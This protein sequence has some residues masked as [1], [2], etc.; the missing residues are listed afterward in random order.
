MFRLNENRSYTFMLIPERTR[1]VSSVQIPAW[2]LKSALFFG[3]VIAGLIVLAVFNYSFILNQLSDNYSLRAENRRLKGQLQVF[4]VKL[5]TLET[6]VERIQNFRDKLRVITGSESQTPQTDLNNIP[7]SL[8]NTGKPAKEIPALK[9]LE[10]SFHPADP[11]K[12]E[13][14]KAYQEIDT[15]IIQATARALALESDLQNQYVNLMDQRDFLNAKPTRKPVV[16]YYTSGFGVRRSPV[17]GRL[18]M[19]EGLDIANYVGAP[20]QATADGIVVFAT[21]KAGYGQTVIVDHGYGVQTWYA[22]TKKIL[23]KRGQK[24]NRGDLVAQLGNSGQ[25]TGPHLHYEIR[26][27]GIPVD[28]LSYILED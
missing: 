5:G 4:K 20:I 18:K 27:N 23:V 9:T 17:G 7:D 8:E 12:Y 15:K 19:H 22:H 25:S 26:I 24:I 21:V 10:S 3:I 13:F 11:E 28:P 2:V 1:E 14:Q 6:S 16:G